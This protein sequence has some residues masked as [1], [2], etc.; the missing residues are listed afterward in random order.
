MNVPLRPKF[1][2]L[3]DFLP[4]DVLAGIEQHV[5]ADPEA[6]ELKDFGGDPE[7]GHY[8]ATRKLW[9]HRDGLGPGEVPFCTAVT[10]SFEDLRVGTGIPPFDL[11]RVETEVCVQRPGSFFAKHIDTDTHEATPSSPS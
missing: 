11:A 6:L 9:V 2:V 3:D 10:D 5:R 4:T 7:E 1:I 8:S